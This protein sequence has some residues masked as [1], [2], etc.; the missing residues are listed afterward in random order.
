MRQRRIQRPSVEQKWSRDSR[1]QRRGY[2][3]K[4]TNS[5][6]PDKRNKMTVNELDK[7]RRDDDCSDPL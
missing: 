2:E 5:L 1:H 7:E 4:P 6:E 3:K